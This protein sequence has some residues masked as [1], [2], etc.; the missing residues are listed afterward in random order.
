MGEAIARC[1][2]NNHS[3]DVMISL[4]SYQ[5][6]TENRPA[7]KVARNLDLIAEHS[8]RSMRIVCHQIHEMRR[9]D[10]PYVLP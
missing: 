8:Y 9:A 1:V 6:D 5:N 3:E 4:Y 10:G 7:S 2:M